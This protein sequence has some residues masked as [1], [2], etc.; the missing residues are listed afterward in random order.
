MNEDWLIT[1]A[2]VYLIAINLIGI[3]VMGID[4]Y[5]AA[6]D[7]WRIPEKTFFIIALTGGSLGTWAGMYMFRHKTKHWYFVIGIPAILA[8]Q[9]ALG[10]YLWTQGYL[11]F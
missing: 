8:A 2:A 4:K 10:V 11:K 7:K 5:K 3:I 1:A 9:I 6:H